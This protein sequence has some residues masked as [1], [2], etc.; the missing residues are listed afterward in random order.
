MNES[1]RGER[2]GKV[3]EMEEGKVKYERGRDGEGRQIKV[4]DCVG[5][6]PGLWMT[7]YGAGPR[8]ACRRA[9][10]EILPRVWCCQA[11]LADEHVG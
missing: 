4:E 10:W 7:K 3:T 1:S 5:S 8:A 2:G 6:A 11:R 9:C